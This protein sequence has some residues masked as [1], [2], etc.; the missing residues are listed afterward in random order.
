MTT[1][2][3]DNAKVNLTNAVIATVTGTTSFTVT[4]TGVGT[5]SAWV[6]GGV[7]TAN[8]T[9]IAPA[10]TLSGGSVIQKTLTIARAPT[11]AGQALDLTAANNFYFSSA[12]TAGTTFTILPAAPPIGT[13]FSVCVVGAAFA[14][15]FPANVAIQG[16]VALASANTTAALVAGP[17]YLFT[18]VV[19]A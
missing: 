1:A 12:I 8:N 5:V 6:S 13:T 19:V 7:A 2:G 15:V 17:K 18:C 16:A 9:N 14:L 4:S 3:T 11:A 10:L